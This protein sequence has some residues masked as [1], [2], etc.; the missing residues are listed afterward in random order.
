MESKVNYTIVG[1]FMLILIIAAVIIPLWLTAGLN[2]QNFQTYIVYM[3]ESVDGLSINSPVKYNG[4][5]VGSV[6]KISLNPNNTQQVQLL[7]NIKDKTPVTTN[8]TAT[9]M[10]QG[11]TGVAYIGLKGGPINGSKSLSI[12]P[13]ETYPEIK[14]VPSLLKRLDTAV[15]EL[16]ENLNGLT[17]SLNGVFTSEN[18]QLINQSLKQLN[19]ISTTLAV[20]SSQLDNSLTSLNVFLQNMAESTQGLPNTMRQLQSSVNNLQ[21]IS[22][23]VKQNPSILLRGK[24]SLPLGPGENE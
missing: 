19:R 16:M 20:N 9:L 14:V 8:T 18:Q 7:L 3:N 13:G 12:K 24:K 15:S 6:K 11:L 10:I 2:R 23:E 22:S 21:S 17:K 5:Q 4:V 1:L